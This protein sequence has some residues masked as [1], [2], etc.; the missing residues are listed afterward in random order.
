[1]QVFICI[2]CIQSVSLATKVVSLY[3]ACEDVC[4][5]QLCLIRCVGDL[6]QVGGFAPPV[7]LIYHDKNRTE[8]FFKLV[9]DID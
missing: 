9:L 3:L 4:S 1:M 6:W 2:L 8:I 5:M 7:K